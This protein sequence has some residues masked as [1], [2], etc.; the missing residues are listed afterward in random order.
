MEERVLLAGCER[1]SQAQVR[2]STPLVQSYAAPSPLEQISDPINHFDLWTQDEE[3]R[4]A[5]LEAR[6]E[7][8][9]SNA[10]HNRTRRVSHETYSGHKRPEPPS[11]PPLPT[12]MQALESVTEEPSS[13]S[14]PRRASQPANICLVRASG[15]PSQIPPPPNRTRTSSDPPCDTV[16]EVDGH[17]I[18]SAPQALPSTLDTSTPT[19][20]PPE[21]LCLQRAE[22]I[23]LFN[24]NNIFSATHG[25]QRPRASSVSASSGS[26]VATI[27][28]SSAST[29][30]PN[31]SPRNPHGLTMSQRVAAL[32]LGFRS[33]LQQGL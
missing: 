23:S 33:S 31:H 1:P 18:T 9:T 20:N 15:S 12:T 17:L 25:A 2:F 26:S 11:M 24:S 13:S 7:M 8:S 22:P 6:L 21:G 10:L 30:P 4:I 32:Q 5:K 29:E 19:F 16:L 28:H 3:T 14:P 27:V